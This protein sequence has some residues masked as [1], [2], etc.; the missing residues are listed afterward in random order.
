[1]NMSYGTYSR[2]DLRSMP[3]IKRREY[4]MQY[5]QN[6]GYVS[7]ILG[8]AQNGETSL[9]IEMNDQNQ[10]RGR[11][12]VVHNQQ[13]KWM[14]QPTEQEIRETLQVTFPDSKISYEEKW[15]QTSPGKQELKKGLTVDWS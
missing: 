1:M 9:M 2:D 8:S 12:I 6:Q 4:L 10:M 11:G 7:R 13:F 14:A 3:G 15:I 5:V